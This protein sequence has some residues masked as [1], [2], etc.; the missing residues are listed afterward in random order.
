MKDKNIWVVEG[1]YYSIL[2]ER[3]YFIYF[4]VDEEQLNALNEYNGK[5]IG[6]LNIDELHNYI[7]TIGFKNAVWK[8]HNKYR[9]G[10]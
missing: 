6:P 7:R 8:I 3:Y 9:E 2:G 4:C 10:N 1:V 5:T